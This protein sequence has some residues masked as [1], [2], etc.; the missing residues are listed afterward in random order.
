MRKAASKAMH[1]YRYLCAKIKQMF[2]PNGILIYRPIHVLLIMFKQYIEELKGFDR[3]TLIVIA[4]STFILLFGIYF[5]R[6]ITILPRE[7]FLNRLMVLGILYMVSPFILMPFFRRRPVDY[8]FAFGNARKWSVEIL[9]FYLLMLVV[10]V[11]AFRLTNL[12]NIYPLYK[13]SA[14]GVHLFLIYQAVQFSH[15]FAWEFFFRGFMLFSLEKKVGKIAVLIQMIP[16]AIMHYRKPE[17]EAYGSIIAGIFLG[18][19]ALR[20]RSFLPCAILHFTVALSA[21]ILG[22]LM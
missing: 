9:V 1:N 13:K 20:G 16:F 3:E 8:G 22:I 7:M 5:R 17:L 18:I 15:M 10:L 2:D 4:Y 11:I 12:K 6:V 21:D 14:H 19:V